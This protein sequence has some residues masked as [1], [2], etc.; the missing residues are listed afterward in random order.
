[1]TLRLVSAPPSFSL[2]SC[3][4]T[5]STALPPPTPT[6]TPTPAPTLISSIPQSPPLT[7]ALHCPH[8]QSYAPPLLTLI[9]FSFLKIQFIYIIIAFSGVRGARTSSISTVRWYWTTPPISFGNTASPTSHLTRANW[10][11]SQ[12]TKSIRFFFLKKIL[13]NLFLFYFIFEVGLE[14]PCEIGRAW[15]FDGASHWALWGGYS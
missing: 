14:V 11:S 7:C 10:F 8:F 4:A 2:F 5:A 15:L 13:F 3:R 9:F 1:M 6:P 12:F